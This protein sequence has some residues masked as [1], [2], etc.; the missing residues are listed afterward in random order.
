MEHPAID[1]PGHRYQHC[2]RVDDGGLRWQRW[3]HHQDQEADHYDHN[4]DYH[5]QAAGQ[6]RPDRLLRSTPKSHPTLSPWGQP[7]PRRAGT[8]PYPVASTN[9]SNS[10][11]TAYPSHPGHPGYPIAPANSMSV[12]VKAQHGSANPFSQNAIRIVT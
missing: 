5:H 2:D 6:P 11:N 4:D 3:P 8:A 7:S 9:S 10:T 12:C 1:F